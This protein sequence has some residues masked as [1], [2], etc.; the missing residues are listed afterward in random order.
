MTRNFNPQRRDDARPPYRD[1]SSFG[2]SDGQQQGNTQRPGKVRLNRSIVDRA[3]Q[4][5]A[6]RN[7]ADYRPRTTSNNSFNTP[8]NGQHSRPNHYNGNTGAPNYNRPN[9]HTGSRPGF[10][11]PSHDQTQYPE[12]RRPYN[13]NNNTNT[14]NFAR[15][16]NEQPEWESGQERYPSHGGPRPHG[17][18][19]QGSTGPRRPYGA[20]PN[21]FEQDQAPRR[22]ERD[23]TP[24]RFEQDQ[25]PR[26]F[27]RDST[28]RRFERDSTP[29][30]FEQNQPPRRFERNSAP[31]R[32]EQDQAPRRSHPGHFEGDYESFNEEARTPRTR[33]FRQA[34]KTQ[35]PEFHVTRLPDGRVLKGP[36]PVQRRNAEFWTE[37]DEDADNLLKPVTPAEP[38]EGTPAK[39]KVAR[40]QDADKPS[41]AKARTPRAKKATKGEKKP[42][43]PKG[44]KPS[45]P[46]YKWPSQD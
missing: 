12:R 7:H 30:R 18:R 13:N 32:F 45:H 15:R 36:R 27:E 38:A 33:N 19:F 31:R 11:S 2:K 29:R 26:R 42:R 25:P 14:P 4:N 6:Q 34:E 44:P 8:S 41:D 23:S 5:G 35:Q 20:G 43:T 17:G 37:I 28:P 24:R 21:R 16:G 40:K 46:G 22:F 39:K 3:W 9:Q 10:S 1:S